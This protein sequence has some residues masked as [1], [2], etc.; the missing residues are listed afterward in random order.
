MGSA[1][2]DVAVQEPIAE[3]KAVDRMVFDNA[4]LDAAPPSKPRGELRSKLEDLV[5]KSLDETSGEAARRAESEVP[6]PEEGPPCA[7]HRS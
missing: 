1:Y 3:R 5:V 4:A 7:Q 6:R 2:N